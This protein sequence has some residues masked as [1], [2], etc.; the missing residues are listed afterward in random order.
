V[1]AGKSLA[2]YW[3]SGWWQPSVWAE[4]FI[5]MSGMEGD[6]SALLG[7]LAVAN[8]LV[9]GRCLLEGGAEADAGVRDSV[10]NALVPTLSDERAPPRARVQAGDILARLGDPRPG[11]GLRPDGLPDIAWCEVPAGPFLMGGGDADE[12]AYTDEKPQH[13]VHLP[14]YRIARYPVTNAQYA[15]FVGDGGYTP[16]WRDCWTGAGWDWKAQRTGPE[17]SGGVYD[18]PNHPVVGVS[19][20]EAVAFCRWLTAKMGMHIELPSEA[21]WEKAARGPSTS[22]GCT[23]RY[24]WGDQADP[25]RANYTDTGIRATSTVGCFP[26]GA[27][28]CGALD[29]AGNVW[30]WCRTKRQGTYEDYQDAEDLEGA[31]GRVVRGGSFAHDARYARCACRDYIVPDGWGRDGGFRVVVVSLSFPL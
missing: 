24:T 16:K 20:Y 15:A 8:P 9:A 14:A 5:L 12:M 22:S 21:Q 10:V 1:N 2:Q 31:A 4:T 27:S 7:D 25:N 28:P 18:L 23:R 29:M 11:V 19:W 30:E 13:E 6:A 26:G 3:P 17:P